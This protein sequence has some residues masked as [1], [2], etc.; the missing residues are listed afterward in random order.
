MVGGAVVGIGV[1][2]AVTEGD[3][4]AVRVAVGVEL[5]GDGDGP[6]SSPQAA[7]R[8]RRTAATGRRRVSLIPSTLLQ[9]ERL[10][11]RHSSVRR[12]A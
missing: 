4:R 5:V 1:A 6:S 2:D 7:I 11:S 8:A 10:I 9:N 3:G 12:R